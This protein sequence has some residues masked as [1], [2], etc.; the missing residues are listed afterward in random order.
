MYLEQKAEKHWPT[1]IIRQA[2]LKDKTTMHLRQR[3]GV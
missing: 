1:G 2:P 3:K